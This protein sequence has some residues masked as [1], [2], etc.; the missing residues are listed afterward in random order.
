M[1][2]ITPY[3]SA[4]EKFVDITDK[5]VPDVKPYYKISNI[6]RVYS[7]FSNR[8]ISN[9]IDSKGYYYV[10][11]RTNY[12]S[13]TCRIHRLVL[14]A[15][16]YHQGCENEIINHIDGNKLNDDLFNL[17][18]STYSSNMYHAVNHG[19][20]TYDGR[21]SLS[22]EQVETICKYLSDENYSPTMIGQILNI[23]QDTIYSIYYRRAY[24]NISSKYTFPDRTNIKYSR[25]LPL[26]KIEDICKEF[27]NTIYERSLM[28]GNDY[29]CLCLKNANVDINKSTIRL[30]Q[31]ILYRQAN[32]EISYK[33]TF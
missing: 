7:S 18:W 1:I 25:I 28:G 9:A 15:F 20:I 33:Y 22:D 6:G 11:L 26:N 29:I 12:G 31:R 32:T 14:M 8:I 19:L 3:K 16:N 30:A 21:G 2:F 13:K 10:K 5:V 23:S 24:L 4:Y 27:Q 17:E